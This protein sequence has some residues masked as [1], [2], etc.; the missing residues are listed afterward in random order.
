M[1]ASSRMLEEP[2]RPD[3]DPARREGRLADQHEGVEA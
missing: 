2:D 1:P 3:V